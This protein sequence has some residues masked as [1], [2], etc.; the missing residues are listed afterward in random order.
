MIR[1]ER[2]PHWCLGLEHGADG[3]ERYTFADAENQ[4]R[5]VLGYDEGAR[6]RGPR[7]TAG[8]ADQLRGLQGSAQGLGFGQQLAGPRRP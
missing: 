8:L 5:Y 6:R 3:R 7:L 1:P 4:R 2:D